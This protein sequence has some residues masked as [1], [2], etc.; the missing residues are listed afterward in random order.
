VGGRRGSS[1]SMKKKGGRR[2]GSEGEK[3]GWKKG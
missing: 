3:T 2:R 1:M